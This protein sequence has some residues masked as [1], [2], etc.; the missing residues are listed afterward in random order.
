MPGD[1]G[2]SRQGELTVVCGTPQ[3]VFGTRENCSFTSA[4]HASIWHAMKARF[5]A[6]SAVLGDWINH[7]ERGCFD[8]QL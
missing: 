2:G 4:A 1:G 6:L 5:A 8:S 3:N 7:T